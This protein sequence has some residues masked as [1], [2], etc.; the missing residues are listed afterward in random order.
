MIGPIG[1]L[2]TMESV[3]CRRDSERIGQGITKEK[4]E[5]ND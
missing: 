5:K 4:G 2:T 1:E 3:E